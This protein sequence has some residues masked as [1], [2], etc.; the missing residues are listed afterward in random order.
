M[1]LRTV[2]A[3]E[4]VWSV[5]RVNGLESLCPEKSRR[6][7]HQVEAIAA[8]YTAQW[9]ARQRAVLS[10]T[11]PDVTRQLQEVCKEYLRFLMENPGFCELA[12][13]RDPDSGRWRLN[14]LFD[15]STVTRE[16][17]EFLSDVTIFAPQM[18]D[19]TYSVV[20]DTAY[21]VC[22]TFAE[23]TTRHF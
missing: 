15:Q 3:F 22:L 5:F 17:K 4:K 7:S 18:S 21:T 13:Q 20:E 23:K 8:Q 9:I 2:F 11:Q 10:R 19:G 1:V 6:T 16:L 14:T 12:T